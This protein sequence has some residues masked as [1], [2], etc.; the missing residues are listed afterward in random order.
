M[1]TG[2]YGIVN[3]VSGKTYIGQ[4]SNIY[5]RWR[6]HRFSL[7]KGNHDNK[8]LQASWTKHGESVFVFSVIDKCAP[9]DLGAKEIE[10]LARVPPEL[11]FNIGVA[12]GNPVLGLNRR[13]ESNLQQSRSR[14]GRPIRAV[15]IVTG[16]EAV[17][18]YPGDV[19][20]F[21]CDTRVAITQTLS[22]RRKSFNGL[23][24]SY[25]GDVVPRKPSVKKVHEK[26]NRVVVGTC[27]STGE[28]REYPRVSAVVED[29]FQRPCVT[30][31][32]S[33]E[34]AQHKD[35][36]WRYLD[37][38]PHKTM[39]TGQRERLVGSRPRGGSRRIV[40]TC[41]TTGEVLV[42]DYVAQA[43]KALGIAP[44]HIHHCASGRLRSAGGFRWEKEG[45]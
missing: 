44:S 34:L 11:R 6:Q 10:H 13:R 24:L 19:P 20:G 12:G 15:D 31:C 22:G 33:G 5:Q 38:L 45:S 25:I 3:T 36:T 7:R 32:L 35:W 23:L 29:G 41:G 8:H 1:L 21:S 14:G 40:G 17:Y 30:R 9:A 16:A 4:A 26:R 18:D 2:V 43:A 42:F 39:S 27:R 28:V 37:G